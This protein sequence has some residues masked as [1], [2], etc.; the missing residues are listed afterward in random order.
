M[1]IN[2]P[3]ELIFMM[4]FCVS[5][6][7][8]MLIFFSFFLFFFFL[9]YDRMANVFF[10]NFIVVT[11]VIENSVGVIMLTSVVVVVVVAVCSFISLG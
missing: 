10:I 5:S 6:S 4:L 2:R 3:S 8:Y 7:T 1:S 9:S 11:G